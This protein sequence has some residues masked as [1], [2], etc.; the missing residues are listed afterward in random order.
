LSGPPR[1][2]GDDQFVAGVQI[3]EALIPLGASGA[4]A[5]GGVGPD[6]F[7]SGGGQCVEL[8]VV[9]LGAGGDPC[10]SFA[11]SSCLTSAEQDPLI[12][13]RTRVNLGSNRRGRAGSARGLDQPL[14]GIGGC[15]MAKRPAPQA[16]QRRGAEAVRQHGSCSA[17]ARVRSR[18]P[19][20]GHVSCPANARTPLASCPEASRKRADN[21]VTP[22]RFRTRLLD[23]FRRACRGRPL[24]E[25]EFV[26]TVLSHPTRGMSRGPEAF[27]AHAHPAEAPRLLTCQDPIPHNP[28]LTVLPH[29]Q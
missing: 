3:S 7:A 5:G 19:A 18:H 21:P 10:V 17:S 26:C 8:G 28:R 29:D 6:S 22:I 15:P 1:E 24:S 4:L 13:P 12:G 25:S 20:R 16:R 14:S 9:G 27:G 11:L 23:T 2:P